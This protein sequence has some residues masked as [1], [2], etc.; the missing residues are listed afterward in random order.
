MQDLLEE[1][2]KVFDA[3]S[4]LTNKI[5]AFRTH[6]RQNSVGPVE[7]SVDDIRVIKSL[8]NNSESFNMLGEYVLEILCDD[9]VIMDAR[10]KQKLKDMLRC[11][12]EENIF[13]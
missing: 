7:L 10:T 12:L 8:L 9:N 13:S 3:F 2:K 4:I 5:D 1:A 11:S 6:V